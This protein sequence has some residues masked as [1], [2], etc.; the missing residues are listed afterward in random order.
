MQLRLST[1]VLSLCLATLTANP[2]CLSQQAE[3]PEPSPGEVIEAENCLVQYISKVK[4]AA[5]SEGV[6]TELH[7]EE[8]DTVKMGQLIAV[9]DDTAAALAVA[10]KLAEEKEAVM[11]AANEVNLED[12]LNAEELASAESEAY[13]DL[14]KEGAIPYW[15]M[16]KK[17]LEAKRAQL[18]IDL[19][20]MQKKIAEVQMIAKRSERQLAEF[21]LSQRQVKTPSTGFIEARYA[22][23]GEWLQP[24]S[25]IA[26]LIQMDRLRVEGDIDALSFRSRVRQGTPVKVVIE[27][28]SD[29]NKAIQIDG[30]LGY[31]SMEIDLNNRHRVWVEIQNQPIIDEATGKVIDWQIKPGMRASIKIPQGS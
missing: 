22:Q 20:V 13:K 9:I 11:N 31:V 6:L 4:L 30:K 17:R 28:D 29:P 3:S 19:A 21:E 24:G 2:V 26:T 27:N 8:G 7:F 10:L 23:L 12:A 14:R 18:R 15:E 1:T 25:P 16:E 5:R